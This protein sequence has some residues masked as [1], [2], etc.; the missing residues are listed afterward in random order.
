MQNEFDYNI[1]EAKKHLDEAQIHIIN[2][3]K[4]N[5]IG[6]EERTHDYIGGLFAVL[7]KLHDITILIK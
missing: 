7:N 1:S 2:C 5:C 6:K 4:P 3:I